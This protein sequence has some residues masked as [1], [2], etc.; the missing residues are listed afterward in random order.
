MPLLITASNP[1]LLY[2][3]PKLDQTE[4]VIKSLK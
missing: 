1:T 2:N 4:G 3:A